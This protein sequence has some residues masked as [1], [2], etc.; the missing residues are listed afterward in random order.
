[1]QAIEP[2]TRLRELILHACRDPLAGI[3][4]VAQVIETEA[5][6]LLET[7]EMACRAAEDRAAYAEQRVLDLESIL[8]AIER[9]AI[10]EDSDIILEL[11]H[12]VLKK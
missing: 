1:M 6:E 9:E 10:A 2:H 8:V 3:P 5:L 4:D 12:E 11:V 7:L